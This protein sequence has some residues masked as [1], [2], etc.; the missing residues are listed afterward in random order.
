MNDSLR[1]SPPQLRRLARGSLVSNREARYRGGRSRV[2]YHVDFDAGQQEA[3]NALYQELQ[4]LYKLVNTQ[5]NLS[6]KHLDAL[7]S[8]ARDSRLLLLADALVAAMN[9]ADL[10]GDKA[11]GDAL[12]EISAGAFASICAYLLLIRNGGLEPEYTQTLIYLARDHLKVMRA[13]IV[14]LDPV[15]RAHDEAEKRHS[16][17]LLLE[18]W[19]EVTY[20]AYG[21]KVS[22]SFENFF[23]GYVAERCLEFAEL[24]SIF[25]HLANNAARYSAD[26]ALHIAVDERDDGQSLVWCFSN[27]ISTGQEEALKTLLGE[28]K[29]IFEYGVATQ[30]SGHGLALLSSAVQNAYGLD[31]TGE[32]LKHGYLG[33]RI[34]EHGIFRVW[35]HWPAVAPQ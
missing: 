15:T 12:Y 25:Y 22:V 6:Q 34:D 16:I 7:E 23:T 32:A 28:E 1:I 19:K 9:D 30:G 11:V 18:K 31:D 3:V 14:D 24:D 4:K 29:N 10:E 21:T 8:F 27:A 33:A 35:F 20:W 5:G 13:N 2:K 26:K 17:D